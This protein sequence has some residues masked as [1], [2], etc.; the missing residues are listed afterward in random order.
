MGPGTANKY[1]GVAVLSNVCRVHL[2]TQLV[3]LASSP[4]NAPQADNFGCFEGM[5]GV[6]AYLK[7][8][9]QLQ[10]FLGG[11]LSRTCRKRVGLSGIGSC[12]TLSP[13][14]RFSDDFLPLNPPGVAVSFCHHITFC[15]LSALREILRLGHLPRSSFI[16]ETFLFPKI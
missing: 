14:G 2:R 13:S 12:R 16:S 10:G 9:W 5:C 15:S 3:T 4:K 11:S 6:L 1:I 7:D 8:V